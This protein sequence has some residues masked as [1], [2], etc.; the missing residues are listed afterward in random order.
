METKIIDKSWE[1]QQKII[2]QFGIPHKLKD[3]KLILSTV[4]IS[5]NPNGFAKITAE[6][7]ITEYPTLEETD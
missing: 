4:T 1:A 6:Y 3:D 7:I 2:K 5:T